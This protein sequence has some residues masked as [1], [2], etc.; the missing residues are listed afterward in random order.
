[1][2]LY[3][4]EWYFLLSKELAKPCTPSGRECYGDIKNAE[5]V[6]SYS[7]CEGLHADVNFENTT[8]NHDIKDS[9]AFESLIEAYNAYK[10]AYV[11]NL[12]LED[13]NNGYEAVPLPYHPLQVVQI[14]FNTDT[15][16][17][18]VN[19][20]SVTLADQLSAI[21]GTMGL[22]TGFSILSV[23]E[24]VYFTMK[25]CSSFMS[26]KKKSTCYF[27]KKSSS[28]WISYKYKKHFFK[29]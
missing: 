1:M 5:N 17:K 23:V 22:F 20:V 26:C 29:I 28:V 18:I 16:D 14:Y 2:C 24:I 9:F 13:T 4:L 10:E 21:G 7:K 25:F 3:K 15:Y 8:Y 12:V 6:C 27:S 19:D 11:K